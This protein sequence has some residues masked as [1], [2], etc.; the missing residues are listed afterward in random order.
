MKS[1]KMKIK[2]ISEKPV[3]RDIINKIFKDEFILIIGLEE[4]RTL[5]KVTGLEKGPA[6]LIFITSLYSSKAAL[7]REIQYYREMEKKAIVLDD[8]L[9]M[10]QDS[11]KK[12]K[13]AGY[14]FLR[15][16][17]RWGFCILFE[18]IID[19]KNAKDWSILEKFETPEQRNDRIVDLL[20][21]D[22]IL[23]GF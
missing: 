1:I 19:D 6:D 10:M 16:D 23:I 3:F 9:W 18:G 13:N 14:G 8:K 7:K 17:N 12:L 2:E 22:K 21:Q 5:L 11:R 20:K 4:D 15:R